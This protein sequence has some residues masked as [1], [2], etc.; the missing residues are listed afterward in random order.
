MKRL[1]FSTQAYDLAG[2]SPQ[3]TTHTYIQDSSNSTAHGR[4][5]SSIMPDGS[6]TYSEYAISAGSPVSIITDYS[7]W[8]D[9]TLAQRS[10]ARR[11]VTTVS[12]DESLV[13]TYVASQLIAKSRTKLGSIANDPF[14]TSE[15]WDGTAWHVTTTCYF[16]DTALAPATG[17]IKWLEKVTT[18]VHKKSN[19][20]FS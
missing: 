12:A 15:K 6:W 9:L 7:G 17:R 5:Q 13:E 10:S 14:T 11:T 8:K 16:Q 18:Q 3:T 2:Q 19:I 20:A 4:L 1:V